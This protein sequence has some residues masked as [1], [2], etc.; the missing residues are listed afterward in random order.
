MTTATRRRRRSSGW[1]RSAPRRTGPIAMGRSRSDWPRA[2]SARRPRERG[3]PPL[4]RPTTPA[5]T[6]A[7]QPREPAEGSCTI[8]PMTIPTRAEAASLLL[9]LDPPDWHLRHSRAVA[10]VAGWIALR[11]SVRASGVDRRLVESSALLH[12]VDKLLAGTDP[13]A[14]L[15]HGDGSAE[16]LRRHGLAELAEP[17]RWHP[18]DRLVGDGWEELVAGRLGAETAIVAYADK[19]AG[20]RLEGLDRRFSAWERRYP[21]GWP[22]ETSRLAF[23]RTRTLEARVCALAGVRPLEVR[24]L[25]WTGAALRRAAGGH[26]RVLA[27]GARGSDGPRASAVPAGEGGR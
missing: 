9:S 17:V 20:Q 21:Q 25:R 11:A 5:A 23:E 26:H 15:R 7:A 13:A 16:W 6:G 24:R 1:R 2:R 8:G 4:P 10:E 14:S 12:D 22:S 19:R 18:V 3:A 27:H